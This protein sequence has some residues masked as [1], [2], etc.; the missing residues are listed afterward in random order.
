MVRDTAD[1]FVTALARDD[2]RV[3]CAL[4]ARE[5]VRHIDD[6]RPEGCDQAL[7]TLRLPTDRPTAV[8]RWDETAQ[9]RSGHDTLFLRKFHE[10]WRIIGAG[11]APSSDSGPYRCKVDGS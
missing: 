1:R 10:G 7:S 5:A 8:S 6:L 4:L 9:A 2:G 3:A 11:C